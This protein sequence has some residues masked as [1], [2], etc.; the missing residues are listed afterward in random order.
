MARKFRPILLKEILNPTVDYSTL[1][2]ES[3]SSP[4]SIVSVPQGSVC[5]C[6][7][8]PLIKGYKLYIE[9]TKKYSIWIFC[10]KCCSR[11]CMTVEKVQKPFGPKIKG[12]HDEYEMIWIWNPILL[13]QCKKCNPS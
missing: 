5:I 8:K 11:N 7:Y 13:D 10:E 3:E 12:T 2:T 1:T 6:C 9:E 4:T